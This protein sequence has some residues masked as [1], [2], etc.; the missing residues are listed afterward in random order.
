MRKPSILDQPEEIRKID[1]SNM[2]DHCVRFP[3][4]CE[5]SIK[6]AKQVEI[7]EETKISPKT[8]IRYRKPGNI[9]I[10]GMGGSAIGGEM[11]R[12]WLSDRLPIPVEIC[13]DYH[14]SAYADKN[15]L[16]FAISYSGETEETLS[17]FVGAV[18]R[19]CM[20]ITITSGGH[21]LSFSEKLNIP[22][23]KI[24]RELPPRA[25]FPYL[26]FPLPIL[27]S[28]IELI[29]DIEHEVEEA[30]S[31]LK[32]VA[33]ENAPEVPI[34][35][36]PSKKLALELEG[37]MPVV[38]GFGPYKAVAHRLKTQFNENSK[39]LSTYDVFPELNH[40]EI[41]GW[42]T[43]KS[44]T[45]NFSVILLRD[46]KEPPEIKYRIQLTKS[47]LLDKTRKTHEVYAEGDGRLAKIL[48]LLF[49]GD[50]LSIYLA[51]L[52][53]VDPSPVRSIEKVKKG[54]REKFDLAGR[55]KAE[56]KN[57]CS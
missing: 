32:R 29:P 44:L 52:R 31:V 26:F 19:G 14:L 41:V 2:L 7:P 8:T 47:M 34:E 13:R 37:T 57:M 24:P 1:K 38:Y 50:F 3:D 36:N 16:V 15:T 17:A 39:L 33:K 10:A 6:R 25:A 12:D 30:L 54:L 48:S 27:L 21:L 43:S 9:L 55:L 28:R 40:N 35:H 51:I 46:H 53:G 45:K 18:R 20:T 49:L 11:L 5:D 23:L 42:E 4:Y 22:H 56:I